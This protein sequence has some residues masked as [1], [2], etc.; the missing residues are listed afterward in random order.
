MDQLLGP[1]LRSE[2]ELHLAVLL[3][4]MHLAPFDRIGLEGLESFGDIADLIGARGMRHEPVHVPFDEAV[5]DELKVRQR[6][7]DAAGKPVA[8]CRDQR[9]REHRSDQAR[10]HKVRDHGHH[11]EGNEH[12]EQRGRDEGQHEFQAQSHGG[13]ELREPGHKLRGASPFPVKTPS[14][15]PPASTKKSQIASG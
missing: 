15:K 13:L 11:G 5:D 6:L 8:E 2:A 3:A 14:R 12:A 10:K 4:L 7:G 1:L 9:C